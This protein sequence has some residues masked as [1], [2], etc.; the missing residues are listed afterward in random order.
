MRNRGSEPAFSSPAFATPNGDIQWGDAG[1]TLREYFA[2]RAP[3]DVPTWFKPVTAPRPATPYWQNLG[4]D[5]R[6]I[7]DWKGLDDYLSDA[8]VHPDVLAY[9]DQ[10]AAIELAQQEWDRNY[11]TARLFQWP[12]YWADQMLAAA[13]VK[14]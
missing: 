14:R 7:A 3:A 5:E 9:R 8:E 2:A 12:W 13:E 10:R 4:W 11:S 1:M 6:K